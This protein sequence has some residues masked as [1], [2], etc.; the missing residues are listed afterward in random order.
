MIT[1]EWRKTAING[2]NQKNCVR[3]K[4]VQRHSVT[5]QSRAEEICDKAKGGARKFKAKRSTGRGNLQQY[6]AV[7]RE[8]SD[9][10]KGGAEKIRGE[11][12]LGQGKSV[13][14]QIRCR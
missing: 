9:K 2:K 3:E 6:K 8:N 7:A 12:K 5:K 13:T 1:P 11:A 14:E 4:P 10:A